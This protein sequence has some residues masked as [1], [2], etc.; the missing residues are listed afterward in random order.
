MKTEPCT[1][2]TETHFIAKCCILVHV[3]DVALKEN[4]IGAN[5]VASKTLSFLDKDF[6]I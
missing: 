6:V 2:E 1:G 3:S 4:D 5:S